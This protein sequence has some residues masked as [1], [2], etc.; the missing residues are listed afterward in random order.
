M[1][2]VSD[3]AVLLDKIYKELTKARVDV[4]KKTKEA[5]QGAMVDELLTAELM[6]GYGKDIFALLG[7]ID[8]IGTYSKKLQDSIG[9][10]D[11]DGN[12]VSYREYDSLD[13]DEKKRFFRVK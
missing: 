9:V 8:L 10:V 3:D 1:R 7:A 2:I 4:S 5:E 13:I 6:I 12:K 11:M